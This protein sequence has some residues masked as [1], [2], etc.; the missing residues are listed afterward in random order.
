MEQIIHL[1][2]YHTITNDVYK[3]G[4]TNR[5]DYIPVYA[6]LEQRKQTGYRAGHEFGTF[7]DHIVD[8]IFLYYKPAHFNGRDRSS[9]FNLIPTFPR[10]LESFI[11]YETNSIYTFRADNNKYYLNISGGCIIDIEGNILMVLCTKS[12][13][14]ISSSSYIPYLTTDSIYRDENIISDNLL[15]MVSTEF[16]TNPIYKT[17]YKKIEKEIVQYCYNNKIDVIFTNSEKIENNLYKNDFDI[18]FNS[19]EELNNTLNS[20]L[21]EIL[22][23][24]RVEE[25]LEEIFGSTT[26][27]N[28]NNLNYVA[29]MDPISVNGNYSD[30]QVFE[31]QED[32]ENEV[33]DDED[34]YVDEEYI[35]EQD[36]EEEADE[37]DSLDEDELEEG[38]SFLE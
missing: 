22:F 29:G 9:D 10:L 2:N 6:L 27:T 23:P 16:L 14:I 19:L 35:E 21:G 8:N 7:S 3:V 11:Q 20:G 37:N 12:S 32:P 30:V 36:D 17:L 26:E 28:L 13:E 25:N 34:D 33:F 5:N 1:H 31:V 18:S 24:P 4:T 15:L 38:E